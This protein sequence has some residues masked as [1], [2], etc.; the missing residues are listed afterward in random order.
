MRILFIGRFQP[1]HK[2]HLEAFRRLSLMGEVLVGVGSAQYDGSFRN[3]FSFEERE[4][5]I[6][7][8]IDEAGLPS[9]EVFPINDIHDH[10]RWAEHVK[11]SVPPYD[12]IFTN[13]EVDRSIFELA[14]ENLLKK[15]FHD[16]EVYKGAKVRET[17]A[18]G[19]DWKEMV[20]AAVADIL[21]EIGA[22]ERLKRLKDQGPLTEEE[23]VVPHGTMDIRDIGE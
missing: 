17:L 2:G 18:S 19:G 20:P 23:Q 22:V 4:R 6:K 10:K 21:K 8:A 7:A 11:S 15:W 1:F 13:A 9:I 16:R 5:M 3:P 14:G 12:T